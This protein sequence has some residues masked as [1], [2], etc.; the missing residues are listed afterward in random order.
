MYGI[1]HVA[2]R[3]LPHG[4]LFF[5]APP[6]AWLSERT[7]ILQSFLDIHYFTTVSCLE[8]GRGRRQN[9][10]SSKRATLQ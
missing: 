1:I 10:G 4:Y 3:C 9:T 2:V 6:P 7:G 5:N 8:G